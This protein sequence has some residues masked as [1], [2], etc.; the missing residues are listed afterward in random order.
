MSRD[1]DNPSAAE[2]TPEAQLL[3]EQVRAHFRLAKQSAALPDFE[4]V[5]SRAEAAAAVERRVGRSWWPVDLFESWMSRPLWARGSVLAATAAAVVAILILVQ[6]GDRRVLREAALIAHH[7]EARAAAE[8]QLLAS[9][10]RTTRWQAPSDRW[11]A[12]H[13]DIDIFGLPDIGDPEDLKEKN[14]W[15]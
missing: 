10:E 5:M 12:V 7:D 1:Q 11:L 15:L 6:P 13:S 3:D 2:Q 14:S 4:T 9:L 8:R